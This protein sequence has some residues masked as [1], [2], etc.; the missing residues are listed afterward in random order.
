MSPPLTLQALRQVIADHLDRPLAD[1]G[2]DTRLVEDL[3][4]DS[5]EFYGLVVEIEEFT[6]TLTALGA[7]R[8]AGTVAQLHQAVMAGQGGA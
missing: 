4:I 8:S 3:A 2:A 7:L 5:L 6:G 1:V